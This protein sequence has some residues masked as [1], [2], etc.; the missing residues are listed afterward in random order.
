M[1]DYCP[2]L[3]RADER[4]SGHFNLDGLEQAFAHCFGDFDSCPHHGELSREHTTS[5]ARAE[6]IDGRYGH[7]NSSVSDSPIQVTIS[8]GGRKRLAAVA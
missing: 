1:A 6:D 5:E 7:S 8:A 3:N 4:C 2:F